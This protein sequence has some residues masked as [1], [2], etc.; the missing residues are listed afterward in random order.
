[1]HMCVWSAEKFSETHYCKPN[2]YCRRPGPCHLL[3][4]G[5][6]SQLTTVN[7]EGIIVNDSV[8]I[9]LGPVVNILAIISNANILKK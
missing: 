9:S 5:T 7:I 4:N 3:T 1:M 6:G 2:V 8:Y